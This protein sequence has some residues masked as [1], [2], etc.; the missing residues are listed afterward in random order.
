MNKTR[1]EILGAGAGVAA[2]LAGCSTQQEETE[3][4]NNVETPNSSENQTD[5]NSENEDSNERSLE[6]EFEAA[7]EM[8]SNGH[9]S[10]VYLGNIETTEFPGLVQHLEEKEGYGEF[11]E[12]LS[13]DGLEE[14]EVWRNALNG[15]YDEQLN[16]DQKTSN[17]IRN[18]QSLVDD[19]LVEI[20]VQPLGNPSIDY[21][22]VSQDVNN[23]LGEFFDVEIQIEDNVDLDSSTLEELGSASPHERIKAQESIFGQYGSEDA[24]N[25]FIFPGSDSSGTTTP[26][27][28]AFVQVADNDP[29]VD[30]DEEQTDELNRYVTA[31]EAVHLVGAKHTYT[32]GLMT[33][34]YPLIKNQV[35]EGQPPLQLNDRTKRFMDRVSEDLQ[36]D[37]DTYKY[38][39]DLEVDGISARAELPEGNPQ[40]GED[41]FL[42][43]METTMQH[44]GL[45]IPYTEAEYQRQEDTDI[46][47]FHTEQ[48]TIRFEASSYQG[49]DSMVMETEDE[50]IEYNFE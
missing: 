37:W 47:I 17:Y 24:F 12:S 25:L 7:A 29:F 23:A 46:A 32:E 40:Q 11:L 48:G 26:L 42:N 36:I 9:I 34:N 4:D 30:G 22:T 41:D 28:T 14:Q 20:S 15:E 19:K 6:E 1:R 35:N 10:N 31:H 16:I 49:L 18:L 3:T 8:V 33:V 44:L 13:E 43:H 2:L 27:T 5:E 45:D 38:S 50:S 39:Q 21:D